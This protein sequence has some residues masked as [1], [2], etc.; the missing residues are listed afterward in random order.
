MGEKQAGR[1]SVPE[2]LNARDAL[3][4]YATDFLSLRMFSQLFTDSELMTQLQDKYEKEAHPGAPAGTVIRTF[5]EKAIAERQ[6]SQE[7]LK[8]MVDA[9]ENSVPGVLKRLAA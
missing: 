2:R 5:E 7:E 1:E 9:I 4:N 3:R 8:I 6:L